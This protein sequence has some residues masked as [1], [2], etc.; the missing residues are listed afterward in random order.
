M[1]AWDLCFQEGGWSG[2]H[3]FLWIGC[4]VT[5]FASPFWSHTSEESSPWPGFSSVSWIKPRYMSGQ[6]PCSTDERKQQHGTGEVDLNLNFISELSKERNSRFL[7]PSASVFY[8][9]FIGLS[10]STWKQQKLT[11]LHKQKEYLLEGYGVA[12]RLERRADEL[13][14]RKGWS[15]SSPWSGEQEPLGEE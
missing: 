8:S 3:S 12:H 13:V 2:S 5:P 9:D 6:V 11:G 7:G 14:F 15:Q 4:G 10:F 1:C